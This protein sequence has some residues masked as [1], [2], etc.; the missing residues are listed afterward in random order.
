MVTLAKNI[1]RRLKLLKILMLLL[2]LI[3]T[4]C[5][6]N[7]K[8]ESEWATLQSAS[9]V[10]CKPWKR[11]DDV[12]SVKSIDIFNGKPQGFL[13]SVAL[14]NGQSALE[15]ADFKQSLSV[16]PM[17]RRNFGTRTGLVS[18]FGDSQAIYAVV[19]KNLKEG[20]KLEIRTMPD[21][22][23][24]YTAIGLPVNI[25]SLE[26]YPAKNGAWLSFRAGHPDTAVEELGYQFAY[27]PT[28][29]NQQDIRLT[30]VPS[31][32]IDTFQAQIISN[33]NHLNALVVWKPKG[34]SH[35]H[36][37]IAEISPGKK[38]V[39]EPKEVDVSA[40]HE[41]E[42]WTAGAAKEGLTLSYVDGDSLIGQANLKVVKLSWDQQYAT[43]EWLKSK[44]LLNEHVSDPVWVSGSNKGFILI[45][46]WV[47]NE[48][49]I[50]LYHVGNQG[51]ENAEAVGVFPRGLRVVDAFWDDDIY[52]LIRFRE[53]QEWQ[54]QLCQI[55]R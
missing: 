11:N 13:T 15:Y 20:S 3:P 21:N 39:F 52:A 17:V 42:S 48:S 54:F 29:L 34:Q 23:V 38:P 44:S 19:S 32:P 14:R 45:P 10:S 5:A 37:N 41:I 25:R 18:G 53:N 49:T 6:F 50:A 28:K 43:T 22:V 16:S 36:F 55:S 40:E 4:S 12:L 47:D 46:K 30:A 26:V 1:W 27:L 2:L 51:F 31:Q 33:P 7:S 9:N 24:R 35:R 8:V